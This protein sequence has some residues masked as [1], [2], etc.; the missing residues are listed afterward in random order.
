[1]G[2]TLDSLPATLET[3]ETHVFVFV[4]VVVI[5]GKS[6]TLVVKYPSLF[7]LRPAPTFLAF[8]G[9]F[10]AVH[11]YPSFATTACGA[12]AAAARLGCAYVPKFLFFF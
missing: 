12:P 2:R 8:N 4:V 7:P 10:T 1:M 9:L 11:R 6:F 3:K 5:V